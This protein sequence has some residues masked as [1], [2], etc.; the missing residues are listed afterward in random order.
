MDLAY[1]QMRNEA[2]LMLQLEKLKKQIRQKIVVVET[3]ALTTLGHD[4]ILSWLAM[5]QP[6]PQQQ[7]QITQKLL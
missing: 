6:K 7:Q 4:S 2:M 1:R 5:N 3:S